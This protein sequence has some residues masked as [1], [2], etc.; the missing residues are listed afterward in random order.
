MCERRLSPLLW[1][2][3]GALA[4]GCGARHPLSDAG[5]PGGDDAG[6]EWD[7]VPDAGA[8]P[9]SED[10]GTDAGTFY[11]PLADVTWLNDADL[12][13]RRRFGL[14][15]CTPA[16]TGVCVNPSGSM[17]YPSA[18][19]WVQAMNDA[20]YLGHGD[21]QLPTTPLTEADGGCDLV[22]PNGASF[23]FNCSSGALA[24]L[25]YS[26]LRLQAPET[27]L[28]ISSS[29]A[30]PFVGFQPYLYWT[31]TDASQAGTASFSFNSGFQ[32]SNTRPNF[33]YVLPMTPGR[34]AGLPA[35]VGLGLQPDPGGAT[36]YDPVADVTWLANANVAA[37]HGFGLPTCAAPGN[38]RL[39]VGRDG[40]MSWDSA[41]QLIA[42]MNDAGY[43]GQTAWALPPADPACEASYRCGVGSGNPLS[44][45]FYGQLKQSQGMPVVATPGIIVGPFSHL[46]PYLYWSCQGSSIHAPCETAGPA[47]GFAWSFSFG[48]GFLGTDVLTNELYVTA[49]FV[50]R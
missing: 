9:G 44:E 26:V 11:D 29:A 35:P 46:Q 23:G 40:A 18:I 25:Y 30:G 21:W 6:M 7:D 39:C 22:G 17:S 38:P 32:G 36:L 31:R 47:P 15:V 33:L 27:A 28:P 14:P 48:N 10:A 5:A 43:L 34:H 41:N 19:A 12:P 2:S 8:E 45:L 49:Y 20:G 1:A 16:G 24:S 4:L 42:G 3:L 37:T 50:G 13:A